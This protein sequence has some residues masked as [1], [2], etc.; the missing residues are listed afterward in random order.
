MRD[1]LPLSMSLALLTITILGGVSIP[2]MTSQTR[3]FI[4]TVTNLQYEPPAFLSSSKFFV[5]VNDNYTCQ[6]SREEYLTLHIGSK[7]NITEAYWEYKK[8][9]SLQPSTG[10]G[11]WEASHIKLIVENTSLTVSVKKGLGE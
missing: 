11:Y 8:L 10:S 2:Q 5:T 4:A 7:V 6:T 1:A 3:S 9:V